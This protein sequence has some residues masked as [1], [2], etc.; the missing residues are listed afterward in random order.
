MSRKAG[1]TPMGKRAFYKAFSDES[2]F[3]D[4]QEKTCCCG[5]CVDGWLA[6]TMMQDFVKSSDLGLDPGTQ[7]QLIGDIQTAKNFY[8]GPYRWKHLERSSSVST[9]CMQHALTSTSTVK[10]VAGHQAHT[11]QLQCFNCSCDHE[12]SASCEECNQ[13]HR[14]HEQLTAH[15]SH[16][17]ARRLSA[18]EAVIGE[19]A[20]VVALQKAQEDGETWREHITMLHDEANRWVGHIVRKHAASRAPPD[21]KSQ[22]EI[23]DVFLTIDY[24]CKPLSR[25][26]REPQ[27]E[28][29]G[30][31]GKSLFGLSA[32]FLK[33][34]LD[35]Y[36]ND[37][38]AATQATDIE[39]LGDYAVMHVRVC[40]DDATQ[41]WWHSTQVF[42][43]AL[44]LLKAKC[45]FLKQAS[46]YS[47]G[48][49]N[50][51]GLAFTA[52]LPDISARTGIRINHHVLPEA[53]DGKDD[54]D[55]DFNGCNILFASY[56]KVD[57]R[58]MTNANEI[59]EALEKGKGH[60]VINCALAVSKV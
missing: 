30:K 48:A 49:G 34:T 13:L 7:Q 18:A 58:S 27:S 38:A 39:V 54:C 42:T 23:G 31:R 6:M 10:S 4:G 50:F 8:D 16:A 22:L 45:P 56:V 25:K 44:L 19:D 20:K 33:E 47:D 41:D 12:H 46:L 43:T 26:N 40:C 28:N 57:G 53:G 9:H 15:V 36:L 35:S 55:R 60:G 29:F 24:K 17:L 37:T 52:M 11:A 21:L 5:S 1:I 2:G 14:L 32:L 3:A 51:K 59:C